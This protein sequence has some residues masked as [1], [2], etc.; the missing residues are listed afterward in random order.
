M[1]HCK[2]SY[3]HCDV[4]FL[5]LKVHSPVT[6]IISIHAT[7]AESHRRMWQ[8][9]SSQCLLREVVWEVC[10]KVAVSH[11]P[12]TLRLP[13]WSAGFRQALELGGGP[14]E[15]EWRRMSAHAWLIRRVLGLSPSRQ[16]HTLYFLPLHLLLST[17]CRLTSTPLFIFTLVLEATCFQ[18]LI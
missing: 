11:T 5:F 7:L 18:G 10:H 4:C 6:V 17:F 14:R 13:Q 2:C 9:L 15:D 16:W 1:P 8:C 12:P 3:S